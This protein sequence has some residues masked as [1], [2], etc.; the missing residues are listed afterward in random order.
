MFGDELS[1]ESQPPPLDAAPPVSSAPNPLP[2]PSLREQGNALFKAG[3]YLRAAVVYTQAIKEEPDN[4]AL[5]SNRS[6]AFLHLS[7]VTKALADAETAIQLKPDWEKGYFRKGCALEAMKRY[8]EAL[9]IFK[10]AKERNPKSGEVL[11]KVQ[12]LTR[13]VREQ[14]RAATSASN[15]ST[16]S[17]S[18]GGEV[19][20]KTA[21]TQSQPENKPAEK[22][23]VPSKDGPAGPMQ[24]DGKVE[25]FV[26]DFFGFAARAW[27]EE[28]RDLS[29]SVTFLKEKPEKKAGAKAEEPTQNESLFRVVIKEGFLSPDTHSSCINFLRQQAIET[30]ALAGCL[31]APRHQV[32]FPQV[33]NGRGARRWQHGDQDGCF[34]QMDTPA[35][36]RVWFVPAVP[37]E[38]GKRTVL[39]TPGEELDIDTYALLLPLF[40]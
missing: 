40:R 24:G 35:L 13:M 7:K 14:K 18:N 31:I 39:S 25:A 4:Q 28:G 2:S 22:S 34:I 30:K 26:N 17:S 33:W 3:N 20:G 1:R 15:K 12:Q 32:A 29:P 37:A 5:Y 21:R 6:A 19:A 11:G 23:D 36:R 38:G 8:D 27:E 16:S 9:S 10:E